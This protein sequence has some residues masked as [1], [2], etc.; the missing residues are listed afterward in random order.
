MLRMVS[1]NKSQANPT[2]VLGNMYD[3]CKETFELLYKCMTVTEELL[4]QIFIG[5]SVSRDTESN[6]CPN[7]W[8]IGW[9]A[10]SVNSTYG[11]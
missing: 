11:K 9:P 2:Q 3:V 1:V 4:D 7:T 5:V 8:E 10:A 6:S